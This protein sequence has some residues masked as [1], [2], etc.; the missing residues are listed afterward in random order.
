MIDSEEK[1]LQKKLKIMQVT[2]KDAWITET[3]QNLEMYSKNFVTNLDS[4]RNKGGYNYFS[5]FI[6]FFDMNQKKLI[7]ASTAIV[8]LLGVVG[9]GGFLLFNNQQE[10]KPTLALTDAEKREIYA[11]M[12]A[13]N[14]SASLN[15][16]Q[17]N[18][19]NTSTNTPSNTRSGEYAAKAAGVTI[20][21][22]Y[23]GIPYVRDFTFSRTVSTVTKGEKSGQCKAI[24]DADNMYAE[25]TST[26]LDYAD[27]NWTNSMSKNEHRDP[28]NR[29]VSYYIHKSRPD[30]SYEN[31]SYMGGSYAVNQITPPSFYITNNLRENVE[32]M[33]GLVSEPDVYTNEEN[34][35]STT[36]TQPDPITIIKDM[37]GPDADIVEKR[38]VNGQDAY[39]IRYSSEMDCNA[40]MR[41]FIKMPMVL[42]NDSSNYTPETK[43]IVYELSVS[44]STYEVLEQI[45][46]LGSANPANVIVRFNTSIDR[47]N[48]SF[49]E[50]E[51][52]FNFDFPNVEVRQ[53]VLPAY[54]EKKEIARNIDFFNSLNFKLVR[55][56]GAN[57][58]LS[59]SYFY[60]PYIADPAFEYWKDRAFYPAG[61]FGDILY[62]QYTENTGYNY[63]NAAGSYNYFVDN[64]SINIQVFSDTTISNLMNN[65]YQYILSS[66]DKNSSS[67]IEDVKLNIG[68]SNVDAKKITNEYTYPKYVESV[69]NGVVTMIETS[70]MITSVSYTYIFELNGYIYELNAYD[71]IGNTSQNVENISFE[72]FEKGSQVYTDFEKLTISIIDRTYVYPVYGNI[73][74]GSVGSAPVIEPKSN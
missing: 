5:L 46:Y 71:Q 26:Y 62:K 54:D 49:A 52:F 37:Y 12:L 25:G 48:I 69:K 55:P 33:D 32:P 66:E 18:A 47:S 38:V 9:V 74:E 19:A 42:S 27:A 8:A 10:V 21:A 35:P 7:F 2:P 63:I 43:K 59:S 16:V 31:L 57:A 29:I 72:V 23:I 36:Q 60:A 28:Q 30:G 22:P 13:N 11:N 3:R 61:E 53:I 34:I 44:S 65:N 20:D 70:E 67:R 17:S 4:K 15:P 64:V 50:A 68:G 51:K 45:T 24:Y 73:S 58:V 40:L 41:P 56:T 6:N 39:V 1:E 14:S